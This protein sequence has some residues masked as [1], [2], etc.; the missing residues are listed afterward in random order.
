[1]NQQNRLR[2][3]S[4]YCGGR[5][6]AVRLLWRPGPLTTC[7]IRKKHYRSR[8]TAN[9]LTVVRDRSQSGC[10]GALCRMRIGHQIRRPNTSAYPAGVRTR[11]ADWAASRLS[12]LNAIHLTR[13]ASSN[14]SSLAESA[15]T[16]LAERAF[17]DSIFITRT[18]RFN[19][20]CNRKV[21]TGF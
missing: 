7:L 3:R 1:M 18:V 14:P 9:C 6:S 10:A 19:Y 5:S 8:L 20:C 2:S 15:R 4:T 16:T 17:V 13:Q 12:L 11:I 21:L